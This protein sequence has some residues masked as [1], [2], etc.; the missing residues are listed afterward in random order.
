M[1]GKSTYM[2]QTALIVIMA[3]MG[4]FVPASAARIGIV[5]RIFTRIGAADYLAFGQ[6][7]FMVEMNETAD[8]LHN[9]TRRSLVLLDEVGRGTS[10]FDGLSIAWAVTEHLH[11]KPAAPRTLFATHYH[12]LT[13]LA[14]TKPRLRNYSIAVRESDDKIVFLRKIVPGGTARS[15]GIQVAKLA[16][17]P[18]AVLVRAREI[19]SRLE[20]DGALHG[21]SRSPKRRSAR[22]PSDV[23]QPDLFSP[24]PQPESQPDELREELRKINPEAI[25]ALEA[26]NILAALKA[27]YT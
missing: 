3:Q 6:S 16:G 1:A 27:R 26:L 18:P 23:N 7:T 14:D 22:L 5:D 2:R 15:F 24:A 17:I 4:S 8:I 10:T 13:E 20:K 21:K 11:D 9:A 12:E 19:L 25:T